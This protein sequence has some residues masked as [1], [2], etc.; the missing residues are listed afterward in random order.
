[1]YVVAH[2]FVQIYYDIK[3]HHVRMLHSV[4]GPSFGE[5][6]SFVNK[7]LYIYKT[8]N[9]KTYQLLY[10]TK[11]HLSRSNNNFNF[12]SYNPFDSFK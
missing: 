10:F 11:H 7:I 12:N 3:L 2:A 4:L 9:L 6:N 8:T 1:M 5:L